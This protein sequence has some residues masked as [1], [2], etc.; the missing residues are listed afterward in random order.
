VLRE[1]GIT[2]IMEHMDELPAFVAAAKRGEF[3]DL[4]S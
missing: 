3:G 1:T 4:L 2:R